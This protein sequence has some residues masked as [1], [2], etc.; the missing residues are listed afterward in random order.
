MIPNYGYR[1]DPQDSIVLKTFRAP[2]PAPPPPLPSLNVAEL[3]S[4]LDF[5]CYCNCY[6]KIFPKSFK[7]QYDS[8]KK[9]I[10]KRK[11][12]KAKTSRKKE[13]IHL[14]SKT[15]IEW[16]KQHQ[17]ILHQILDILRSPEL[18]SFPHFEKPFVVYCDA[19]ETGLEAVLCLNQDGKLK[20]ISCASRTLTPAEKNYHHHFGKLE[21]LALE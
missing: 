19:S 16:A 3:R 1:T 8:L 13:T 17:L 18:M 2:L 15:A 9:N 21:F 11:L 20:F 10:T 6:V 5:L 4:L 14:D 12:K 7:P